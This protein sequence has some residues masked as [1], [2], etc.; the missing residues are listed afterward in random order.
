MIDK[1]EAAARIMAEMLRDSSYADA[2]AQR[3]AITRRLLE[4]YDAGASTALSRIERLEGLLRRIR[5][6]V[7]ADVFADVRREID[8][9][10]RH[11]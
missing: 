1:P 5:P 7:Q 8:E 9:V 11:D 4:F 6:W 10:L 3:N 2:A